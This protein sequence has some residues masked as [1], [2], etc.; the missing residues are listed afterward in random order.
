LEGAIELTNDLSVPVVLETHKISK[1]EFLSLLL[2]LPPTAL[3]GRPP[4]AMKFKRFSTV[5]ANPS[6]VP[7]GLLL[8]KCG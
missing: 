2:G 6:T 3:K 1:V 8:G 7:D 5:V 4:G